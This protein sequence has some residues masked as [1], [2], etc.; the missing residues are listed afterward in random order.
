MANENVKAGIDEMSLLSSY[1]EAYNIADKV[2]FDLSLARGLDYYTGVIF[3]VVI[4]LPS[5]KDSTKK[6]EPQVGS[7]AAGGRYDNLVGKYC[8]RNVPCVGILFGVERIYTILN[9]R[10]AKKKGESVL[11]QDLDVYVV[12]VGGDGFLLERM[13]ICGQLTKAGIRAAFLRKAKPSLRS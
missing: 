12:A 6:K 1:L 7:I 2:S 11:V 3:E 13:A 5:T 9:A 8:G 4:A 10:V